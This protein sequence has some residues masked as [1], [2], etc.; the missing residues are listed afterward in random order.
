MTTSGAEQLTLAGL[1]PRKRRK[2]APAEHTPAEQHPIAQV[3]LDVQALHLGQT[4]DYFID[5]KDSEAAQ[6]GVLLRVRF[7]GQRVSGVIWARTDTSNTPRSSI[8]YIERVLSPDVLVPASMR[9]DIGLIAKAYGGTRANILRFAVPPR[10]AKVE[11]EQRLAASFRRPVGG[12]LSDNMQGGFA[13]RGTNPDGTMPAGSTFAVASTV[14]E[15][16]AQGYRRLTANYADVNVLHDA[17]TGQ[18]FQSFVFD[19][20]PG[21][22]EWQRNMAWMVATALSAGK[23]AVVELPTMREVEDLMPMLRNYGLKPFAPAPAGGWVGDVAVLNAETMPAADRY[24][25][26]LAVALGQV[27]VVIGTRAVMYAPVE[28]PALFAILEDAAYQNMDGMMPY[29]QARGVMRLR[30]KSHGGVFVAM[31]NARTPQSQWENTGPGTVETPVSGYS[32]TI[33]PLASPLKDATPWVRWLNRDELARLADPSIGAR[34]PHTAVRVLSKA[35]ESGPVLLSIP[36]DSVSETL[37]CAKCH[38]QARCAKCSGPLQLPA[39]RRDSTPR[40]R[41][42]GA[43][44]INWKCPG[45]GHERMRVVR[46]GAA[47]TA[48]E[49]A[50]L[51]RGVPVVLSSKT[52]G[53]VRDVACQPM[54][55]IATPGFEPRVRPVSAEQGSAGHEYRAVAVLDA[56]TSLYALGVDA[57]LD[58]LTAW[59]RAVS[60]CAPRSRGGQALILGETDPAIAQSLMLWDSRILAAKD[61]E[62]RVET[63]MPP[64]VAAACV[65]GRRDAVMTLMQRIGALGGD[66]TACGELPGMLGPVPIAQPDT[67]DARELEATADRVKAVIRVP[68]SRRA[69]LAARL[70]RETARHVASREPGELRFRVDPKDLI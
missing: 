44:A 42:C 40:C 10:V 70:H 23:A 68:Q 50:G 31:A 11:A 56:W 60:L 27:K 8:R 64:A 52:Q 55:V 67:V 66:W 5:E 51:F 47:G 13:G 33:H 35:L 26:Y 6:P 2:R 7:G 22:Q 58:T 1:A 14:S 36:Q 32:T 21:A 43:A 53:L 57:R 9:E 24:R 41:W 30:A 46:V 20:L 12:S 65:W 4:F 62:E 16:A 34:V 54:I 59:M 38:R 19:S 3:V 25:T 29:P 63:G 28:G 45:C 37:S 49:L 39:D 15:G 48:A 61:L 69:E 18:R 17:L